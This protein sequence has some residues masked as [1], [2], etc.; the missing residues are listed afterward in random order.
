MRAIFRQELQ[1]V[2]DDLLHMSNTVAT[3]MRHAAAAL[4]DAD[5]QTAQRVIEGDAAV[6]ALERQ[7][8][9][10][11]ISLLARQQPVATDLRV[12]VSALRMS[13][14]VE[15]MGDLARHVAS[16]ARGRYPHAVTRGAMQE[17]LLQMAD[18]AT[19]VG[20]QV[21]Q[22]LESHDLELAAAI[23]RD[24]DMLDELH[25]H[26]FEIMLAPESDMTPQ[27]IVD[28]VLLGR[29]LERFGDHG[30]SVA[31]RISYLVT[32]DLDGSAYAGMTEP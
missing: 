11:C 25:R 26:T 23:Q 1:Q 9:E 28:A 20:E 13:A 15:R 18:A 29:Y 14:T 12:V 3:A 31:R 17:T 2:G 21:S 22:L 16:V 32:G 30:V 27:E 24:D 8:D 19:K 5:L 7:L 10:Q 6:D 4:R